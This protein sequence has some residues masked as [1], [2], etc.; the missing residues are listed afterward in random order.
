MEDIDVNV[1]K[2]LDKASKIK[3]KK[4]VCE[5]FEAHAEYFSRNEMYNLSH[6]K[7]LMVLFNSNFSQ[8]FGFEFDLEEDLECEECQ[9][10]VTSLWSEIIYKVWQREIQ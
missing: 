10:I 4:K 9:T 3:D 1:E 7:S 5:L 2:V 8:E 6:I